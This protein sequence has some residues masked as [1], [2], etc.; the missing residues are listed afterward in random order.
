MEIQATP[1]GRNTKSPAGRRHI[2]VHL[3]RPAHKCVGPDLVALLHPGHT[4]KRRVFA[5][6]DMP[7]KLAAVG[8]DRM[9]PNF[10]VV[11]HVGVCHNQHSIGNAGATA[12]LYRPSV[13]RTIFANNTVFADFKAGRFPGILEVLRGSSENGPVVHMGV[14]GNG[15]PAVHVYSALENNSRADFGTLVHQAPRP[16]RGRLVDFR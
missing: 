7:P 1:F 4:A 2:A 8:Y 14:G 13:E 3:E 6:A 16:D 15:N 9:S 12:P 5:N 10:A 11:A